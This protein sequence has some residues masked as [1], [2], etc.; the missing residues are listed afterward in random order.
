[1]H[2]LTMLHRMLATN[3]PHIHTKRL[4]SVVAAVEAA[5]GGSALTLSSL[6]R[7][8]RSQ[9]AVKH[10]IKRIDRLLGNGALHAE[11]PALYEALAKQLVRKGLAKFCSSDLQPRF[12]VC[13]MAVLSCQ[14]EGRPQ[15]LTLM[16]SR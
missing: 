7:G 16:P 5:V 6:G 11:A 3:C 8:L 15:T 4:T 2:A 14:F 12:T 9:V 10:S 1:M 13:V